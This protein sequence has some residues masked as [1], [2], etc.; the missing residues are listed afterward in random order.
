MGSNICL[1]EVQQRLAAQQPGE[2]CADC[3][4]LCCQQMELYECWLCVQTCK[5]K[6]L[7]AVI[8]C[9]NFAGLLY[10]I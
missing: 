4:V 8:Q 10:A 6:E 7:Q 1:R 2:C 5:S 9:M 3:L